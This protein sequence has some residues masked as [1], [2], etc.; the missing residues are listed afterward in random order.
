MNCVKWSDFC[1][2]VLI[3]KSRFQFWN[4]CKFVKKITFLFIYLFFLN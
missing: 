1:H 4:V 2:Y 3:D